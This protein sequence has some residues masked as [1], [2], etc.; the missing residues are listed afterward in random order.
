LTIL[1]VVNFKSHV[2]LK[3]IKLKPIVFSKGLLVLSC[4][5]VLFGFNSCQK[6]ISA[7]EFE[8]SHNLVKIADINSNLSFH[9]KKDDGGYI[10]ISNEIKDFRYNSI[11]IAITDDQSKVVS[12]TYIGGSKDDWINFAKR[13]GEGN[14]YLGGATL[15]PDIQL[16]PSPNLDAFLAKL[17]K[18]GRLLW[19]RAFAD[20]ASANRGFL[21]DRF[22]SVEFVNDRIL[23][24]GL[25]DNHQ[26]YSPDGRAFNSD[27]IVVEYD[28]DGNFIKRNIL[29]SL[30]LR[31]KIAGRNV[32]PRCYNV[33]SD[34]IISST[35][36]KLRTFG[37]QPIDTSCIIMRYNPNTD[38]VLWKEYYTHDNPEGDMFVGKILGNGNLLGMDSYFHSFFEI[39]P[40]NGQVL[41]REPTGFQG[42]P[43]LHILND[44]VAI[45]DASYF[46]GWYC[47]GFI[48][49]SSQSGFLWNNQKPLLMKYDIDGN[50]EF[51]KHYDLENA[52]F[53]NGTESANNELSLLGHMNSSGISRSNIFIVDCDQKGEIIKP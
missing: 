25:T 26:T 6:D 29:P 13:D 4:F 23:W 11:S 34:L 36:D 30:F 5:T 8:R 7:D 27:N 14:I 31:E 53:L 46:M 49:S 37:G 45:G 52:G 50:L 38:S 10:F 33:G 21:I 47:D 9:F 17:D 28:Q 3:T 1:I 19:Q 42:D 20:T 51:V 35:Y 40:N 44:A 18:N 41:K 16:A 22:T 39:D 43:Q 2:V 15:S 12:K 48:L 24:I 32:L